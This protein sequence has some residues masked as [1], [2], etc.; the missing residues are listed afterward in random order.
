MAHAAALLLWLLLIGSLNLAAS[1]LD[2]PSR[3]AE[4]SDVIGISISVAF[5]DGGGRLVGE[6][7]KDQ[8]AANTIYGA[9]KRLLGRRFSDQAVQ[10]EIE[11]LPFAVVDKDER[12]YVQVPAGSGGEDVLVLSPEEIVAEVLVKLKGTAEAFLGRNVTKA[13]ITVPAY[14][15]DAQRQA[16][17]DA[18][19]I[20]GLKVLRML[21]DPT[22]AAIAYGLDKGYD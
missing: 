22:A 1:L 2:F 18:G 10:R 12:P 20:A 3:L 11:L 14:Y 16:T 4:D 21:N 5:I 19:V 6:A 13:V 9:A 8:H 7:T 15:N 17:R